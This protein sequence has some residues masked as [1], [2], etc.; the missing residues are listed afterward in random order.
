MGHAFLHKTAFS[1]GFAPLAAGQA[2]KRR[3]CRALECPGF[4]GMKR[5][6]QV[7]WQSAQVAAF[8]A[9]LGRAATVNLGMSEAR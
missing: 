3:Q 5:E 9:R 7:T 2:D 6:R 4:M 1:L 8:P